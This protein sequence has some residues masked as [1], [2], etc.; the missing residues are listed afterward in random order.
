VVHQ[1]QVEVQQ[2]VTVATRAILLLANGLLIVIG[3]LAFYFGSFFTKPLEELTA[4]ALL[5]TK[6]DLNVRAPETSKDETGTLARTFNAMTVQLRELIGSLEQRVADR[7]KALATSGELS[8]RLSTI[9]EQQQLVSEVVEQLQSAFNYYHVHIYL[10]DDAN[11][12]LELAGGTGEAGRML[13]ERGHRLPRGRGLVGRAADSAQSI[14]VP[15][16]RQD[17]SWLPNPLLPETRS[18]I[19]VPITSGHG[20]LGVLDVQNNVSDSLT[21]QDAEL[22]QSIAS[23]VAIALQ[24]IRSTESMAKRAKE[25]A[26]V[27]EI[28]NISA[29]QMDVEKML[30]AVVHQ[31]QRLFGLYHAHVFLYDETVAELHIVACGWQEGDLHE[32]TQETTV[33]PLNQEQSLVARAARTRQP[34]IVNNVRSESGW[35]PNPLLLDTVSEMA[36]PLLVGDRMLGV[37]DVQSDRLNAFTEEDAYI[38]RTLASQVAT[39]LQNART[40]SQSR[41]QAERESTLNVI[42][43]RIQKTTSIDAALKIAVRELG[44]ALGMKPTLVTLEPENLNGER[45]IDS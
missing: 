9:T 17:P 11:E 19:A 35:L 4:I 3:L 14:V 29:Q 15:N 22:I 24:N 2:P 20:V 37:L 43:Q 5:V 7:T 13:L 1:A 18:E 12:F 16:T 21:Q 41:K 27:A 23:Q 28:S 40:F 32:G 38:Q 6:G 31:T 34:V 42:G 36:V 10:M 39:S 33:I 26:S 45:K 8:R 44:H 30:T 25:L